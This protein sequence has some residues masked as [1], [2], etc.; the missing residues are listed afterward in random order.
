LLLDVAQSDV[1]QGRESSL[2]EWLETEWKLDEV[3]TPYR[4]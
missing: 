3:R 4:G 1:I 2:L